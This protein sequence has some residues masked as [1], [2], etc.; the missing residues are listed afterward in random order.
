[1]QLYVLEPDPFRVDA[2]PPARQR[3]NDA[4]ELQF[5]QA[6]VHAANRQSE[7]VAKLIKAHFPALEQAADGALFFAE[8]GEQHDVCRR[9]RL[10]G[11]A[12]D[13]QGGFRAHHHHL[14][15]H[16]TDHRL[17]GLGS[18]CCQ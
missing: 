18:L 16:R 14:V 3:L 11:A 12:G 7:R 10:G 5:R 13:D 4:G 8:R 2:I 17:S 6:R 1:M 15:D 9:A